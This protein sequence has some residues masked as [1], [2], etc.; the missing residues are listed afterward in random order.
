MT[1]RFWSWALAALIVVGGTFGLLGMAS[2]DT[3]PR[4]D[5]LP[6]PASKSW[7]DGCNS[8]WKSWERRGLVWRPVYAATAVGCFERR[9]GSDAPASRSAVKFCGLLN[10]IKA[11]AVT[12]PSLPDPTRGE[13]GLARL[14]KQYDELER[15][16]PTAPI[17]RW[18]GGARPLLGHGAVPDTPKVRAAIPSAQKLRTAVQDTCGI[19]VTDVFKIGFP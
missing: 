11:T 1:M 16:A 6:A 7:F 9:D 12:P 19:D 15:V 8:H 18:L 13:A 10:E 17:T 5:V 14:A 4:L 3:V 2:P